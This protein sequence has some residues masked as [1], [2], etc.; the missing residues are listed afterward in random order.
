MSK[1]IY[2]GTVVVGSEDNF[3][4]EVSF[5]FENINICTRIQY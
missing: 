2:M 4:A 5:L 3:T 1:L